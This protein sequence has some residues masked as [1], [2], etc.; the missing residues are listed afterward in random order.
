MYSRID[1]KAS[2]YSTMKYEVRKLEIDRK[3]Y[4]S[5]LKQNQMVFQ[6]RLERVISFYNVSKKWIEI[7]IEFYS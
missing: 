6:N 5:I 2:Y 1:Q 7:F 4:Y 3:F